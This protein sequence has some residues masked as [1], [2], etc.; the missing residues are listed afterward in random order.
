MGLHSPLDQGATDRQSTAIMEVMTDTTGA[1]SRDGAIAMVDS[2][3]KP[4][5]GVA[6]LSE[7]LT[8][9]VG[10]EPDWKAFGAAVNDQI[11]GSRA[12]GGK[13]TELEMKTFEKYLGSFYEHIDDVIA[14]L[15]SKGFQANKSGYGV[16]VS[17]PT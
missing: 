7:V 15:E 8:S 12:A 2:V 14:A 13:R 9:A 16:V 17:W 5:S 6:A 3:R 11:R 1:S 4:S 10:A